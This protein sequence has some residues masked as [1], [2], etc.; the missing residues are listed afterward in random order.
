MEK[1]WNGIKWM[2]LA[3]IAAAVLAGCVG[4]Q[5]NNDRNPE[6]QLYEDPI[7]MSRPENVTRKDWP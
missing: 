5:K 6:Q 4:L 3:M 2:V 1:K 7:G